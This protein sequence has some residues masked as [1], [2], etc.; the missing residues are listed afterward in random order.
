[1]VGSAGYPECSE[2][3]RTRPRLQLSPITPCS[4]QTTIT[5]SSRGSRPDWA[6]CVH[7]SSRKLNDSGLWAVV[8][9]HTPRTARGIDGKSRSVAQVLWPLF[10]GGVPGII[11]VTLINDDTPHILSVGTLDVLGTVLDLSA[12]SEVLTKV[13]SKVVLDRSPRGHRH[14]SVAGQGEFSDMLVAPA[15]TKRYGVTAEDFSLQTSSKKTPW[16]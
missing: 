6:E 3:H 10:I 13:H 8:L 15:D 2:P 12:S 9:P 14:E 16:I 11:D 5:T 7:L 4:Q 1:M